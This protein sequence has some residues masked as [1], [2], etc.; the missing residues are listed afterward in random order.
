M[1]EF[2]FRHERLVSGLERER[3]VQEARRH[4]T[5]GISPWASVYRWLR[6]PRTT[7]VIEASNPTAQRSVAALQLST[8]AKTSMPTDI[9][10]VTNALELSSQTGEHLVARL[11]ELV[12]GYQLA[13][14]VACMARLDVATHITAGAS[15]STELASLT[16][17]HAE[18]L[19]RFLRAASGVGLLEEIGSD[20]FA[21]T[22]LG[23]WLG[24]RDDGSSMREFAI[25][26]SGTALTRTFE[27]LTEAVMTGQP[28]V[29]RALGT[30]MY[31][32]LAAHPD[33][34]AHFAGAMGDLSAGSAREIA[35]HFDASQFTRIVDVG[36][37]YGTVL[38]HMLQAAPRASGVLFDRPEVIARAQLAFRGNGMSERVEFVGGDF[39]QAVPAGGD[40]Y[41]LREILH[42]WDDGE[43]VRILQNCHAA[44]LP[45]S[46]L[47]AVEMVLPE[48]ADRST[49]LS[50]TQDLL[51][52][53][54][55]G[56]KER[57]RAE[58]G[59]LFATAGYR[60]LQVL[61][62]PALSHPWSLLV[63][64]RL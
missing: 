15:S 13:Q 22:P 21:L 1:D 4:R 63:A 45:R 24:R 37:S 14:I 11:T 16:G 42:N 18:S 46:C 23:A 34:A 27:H 25:G 54:V 38:H 9:G 39:F 32:Y 56:G 31:A 47:L 7:A 57:T 49:W 12:G 59:E 53:I 43:A 36:G 51:A 35:A 3:L 48:R 61:P 6:G 60:L 33:E 29:E 30:S 52:L 26:L 58:F 17:A 44:A 19:R 40:L 62:A 5:R 8:E 10:R 64:E 28:V 41:V 20:R 50:F 55:F 2:R